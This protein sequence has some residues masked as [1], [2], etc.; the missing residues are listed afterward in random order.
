[1]GPGKVKNQFAGR[2]YYPLKRNRPV[3]HYPLGWVDFGNFY[4][5]PKWE[6]ALDLYKYN[7]PL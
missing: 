3:R 2:F 7:T 6:P 5:R 1:M 4:L